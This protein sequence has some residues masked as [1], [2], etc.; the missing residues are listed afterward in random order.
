MTRD[1]IESSDNVAKLGLND[2][3][4]KAAAAIVATR[5]SLRVVIHAHFCSQAA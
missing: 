5:N 1:T 2:W 4:G 3:L